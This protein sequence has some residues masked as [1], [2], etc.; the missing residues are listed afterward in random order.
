MKYVETFSKE[1][2]VVTNTEELYNK[3]GETP[4]GSKD[5]I[6]AKF[7]KITFANGELQKKYQILTHNNSPYDPNG[8]DSHRESTLSTILKSVSQDTFDYYV[9]YLKTKNGLYMTRAQR[10]FINV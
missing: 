3:N 6:F 5:K 8:T 7:N 1:D 10:S 4:N 9:L 2:I